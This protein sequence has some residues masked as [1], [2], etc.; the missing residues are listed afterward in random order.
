MKPSMILLWVLLLGEG[1]TASIW[2]RYIDE[3]DIGRKPVID[4]DEDI[5]FDLTLPKRQQ[6]PDSAIISKALKAIEDLNRKQF[7]H[8]F[9]A[10]MLLDNC[11]TPQ[12]PTDPIITNKAAEEERRENYLKVFA[13]SL[14]VCDIEALQRPV[15]QQCS[16]YTQSTLMG[17]KNRR[18]SQSIMINHS[19]MSGCLKAIGS[20]QSAVVSW[21]F[22]QQ[23]T[24]VVC[25]VARMDIEK[26]ETIALFSTLTRLMADVVDEV[27]KLSEINRDIRQEAEDA[28]SSVH[29]IKTS[30]DKLKVGLS[31]VWD[32]VSAEATKASNNVKGI[33]NGMS[34]YAADVEQML[35]RLRKGSLENHAEQAALQQRALDITMDIASEAQAANKDMEALKAMMVALY[36]NMATVGNGLVAIQDRQNEVDKQSAQVLSAMMNM[37]EQL[38]MAAKI[39]DEHEVLLVRAITAASNLA[40]IVDKST[41]MAS[42]WQT[43]MFGSRGLFGIDW[44]LLITTPPTVLVLGSYGLGPSLSRNTL[45]LFIGV[46]LAKLLT[47]SNDS[48][49]NWPRPS[50]GAD[51][52]STPSPTHSFGGVHTTPIELIRKATI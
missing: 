36:S 11:R 25:Q 6:P 18:G 28:R 39:G 47:M 50:D 41:T 5:D 45:L 3:D 16:P 23:S 22:N 46:V 20:D 2:R 27:Q 33:F 26:D 43:R 52:P 14:T 13:V 15:P 19:E 30:V 48:H 8:R 35:N 21:K 31:D 38:Q 7:C 4:G 24:A 32:G 9:A 42:T 37:T 1:C 51:A 29:T 10:S 49:Q 34:T 44:T 40:D 17:I 12:S